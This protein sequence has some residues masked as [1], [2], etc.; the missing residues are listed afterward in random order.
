[1]QPQRY[2]SPPS[3]AVVSRLSSHLIIYYIVILCYYYVVGRLLHNHVKWWWMKLKWAEEISISES[4]TINDQMKRT[5]IDW[6]AHSCHT[7]TQTQRYE[8]HIDLM[9]ICE[10][11]AETCISSSASARDI[12]QFLP[13]ALRRTIRNVYFLL[14]GW[15]L[16]VVIV[17]VYSFSLIFRVNCIVCVRLLWHL[18]ASMFFRWHGQ[19]PTQISYDK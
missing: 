4:K 1:M 3:A 9:S 8:Y 2:S 16:A 17:V 5:V 6:M 11:K 13:F 14:C 19:H 7:Q 15:M 18:Y 10:M 12:F